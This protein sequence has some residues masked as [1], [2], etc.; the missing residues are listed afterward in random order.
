MELSLDAIKTYYGKILGASRDL[1]TGACT[2]RDDLPSA[3]RAILDE[4]DPEILD[5]F[6]G[7]GSPIPPALEGCHV[8]DLGCGSG[9]DVYLLS[10][11]VGPQGSV[12]G[13]DMT[14]EQIAIARSH[15]HRQAE[16]FGF[17]ASNVTF[18]HGY[19][20]DLRALGIADRSFDLVVSN[21]A[22][23]LSPAKDLVFGEIFRVLKPGGELCFS[24]V[25]ADRRLPAA[26]AQDPVL[27]GECLAGALYV[28]DFRRILGAAGCGDHRV[29]SRCP[30]PIENPDIE[31]LL[32]NARFHTMTI[33]AFRLPDLEDRCEDYG[34]SA[35][36]LGT[37]PGQPHSFA[38]DDHHLFETGRPKLVCG[39]TA[40]MLSET[41]YA[42]FFTVTGDRARHFGTFDCAPPLPATGGACC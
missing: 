6:Y 27:L 4:I 5:R 31:A 20:E 40:A 2:C 14:T 28:E 16:R 11:L 19:F 18:H 26:L 1:Q 38:L 21:C 8:L 37:I 39:N 30:T 17:A 41:R 13:V 34:Q 33:R 3:H 35:V 29:I 9:R 10:R 7:C 12:T 22:I 24:D 25:F 32:G 23:N 36:Y 15:Q 42:R